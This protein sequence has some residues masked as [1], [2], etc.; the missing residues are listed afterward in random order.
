[1]PTKTVPGEGSLNDGACAD[2]RWVSTG[3]LIGGGLGPPD[4]EA[5][6]SLRWTSSS[7]AASLGPFFLCNA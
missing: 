2:G 5:V 4:R 3:T 7:R 1:M 6:L